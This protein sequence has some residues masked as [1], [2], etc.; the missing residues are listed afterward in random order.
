[1][2]HNLL[3]TIQLLILRNN[4]SHVIFLTG[5]FQVFQHQNKD[6]SIIIKHEWGRRSKDGYA[7]CGDFA[8]LTIL[9]APKILF[10]LLSLCNVSNSSIIFLFDSGHC[11]S[12]EDQAGIDCLSSLNNLY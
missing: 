11:F 5:H 4:A 10:A 12:I 6:C 7:T 8:K 3:A 1:M 9:L 2:V